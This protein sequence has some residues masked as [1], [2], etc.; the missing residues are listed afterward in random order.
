V[1]LRFNR[2]RH[3]KSG[4]EEYIESVKITIKTLG[5]VEEIK[6]VK[7]IRHCDF[8]LRELWNMFCL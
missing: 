7:K 8:K 3:L 4:D 2:N 5:V 6:Q 1:I